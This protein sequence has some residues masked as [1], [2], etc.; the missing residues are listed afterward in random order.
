MPDL[1]QFAWIAWLVVILVCVIIELLSLEFTFLMIAAGSVGGLATNLLGGPWWLQILVAL[2]LSV[3]LIL[4]IRPLLLRVMHRGA[5][6]T[7]S[8]VDA[9]LGMAGRVVLAIGET[10]GQ[11]RLANGET[12]TA[13]LA[14]GTSDPLD[15]G[16][17]VV[18]TRIQG[19]TAFVM[20][21]P[22]THGAAAATEGGTP[23]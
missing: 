17:P 1:T 8:N 12:W 21:A 16:T 7:P 19:S 13:H 9:L 2:A 4:T 10:G 15:A 11:A 23:E 18:V 14:P 3:L 6:P 20:R 5:D 22:A